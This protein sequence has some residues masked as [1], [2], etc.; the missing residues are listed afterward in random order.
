MLGVEHDADALRREVIGPPAGDLGGQALLDLQAAG[1]QVDDAGEL[2]QPQDALAGQVADVR[3]AV[4]RQQVV[5][6]ERV[7]RNRS[8]DDQ[9]VVAVGVRE[10]R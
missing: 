8:R 2:R 9:L 1:E 4:E 6:E 10:R 5:L 7:E 3:D